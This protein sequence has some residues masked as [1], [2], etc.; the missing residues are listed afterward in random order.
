MANDEHVAILKKGVDA[1][2]TWRGKNPDVVP[3]L[4]GENLTNAHL[5]GRTCARRTS[6][7]WTSAGRTS[8]GQSSAGRSSSQRT[9]SRR[10]SAR[11]TSGRRTYLLLGWWTQILRALI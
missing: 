5:P 10:P 3:D 11:R 7:R 4:S 6:A 8:A 2:N 9:S 1:W